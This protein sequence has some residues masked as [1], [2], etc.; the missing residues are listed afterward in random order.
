MD[1]SKKQNELD[2]QK[3]IDSE[4]KSY[5]TCGEYSYCCKC[6][7]SESYPCAC[8]YEKFYGTTTSKDSYQTKTP[9]TT[10]KTTKRTCSRKTT[11][12]KSTTTKSKT[13]TTKKTTT[14]KTTTKVTA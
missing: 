3:W 8:A 14:K 7:K 9:S 12:S 2:I 5:D 4:T 6:N 10:T 13:P 1:Y 11:T